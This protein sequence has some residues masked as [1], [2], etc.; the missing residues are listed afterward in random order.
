MHRS[1]ILPTSRRSRSWGNP[2]IGWA[3]AGQQPS[4]PTDSTGSP[5]N[6]HDSALFSAA[7]PDNNSFEKISVSVRADQ[8]A[9]CSRRRGIPRPQRSCSLRYPHVVKYHQC[10]YHEV[11]RTISNPRV[12]LQTSP[13]P[14]RTL[15]TRTAAWTT[16][17]SE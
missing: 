12:W 9:D 2:A 7:W 11:H 13:R 1:V 14:A 3:N 5:E 8:N 4:A 10:C 6:K 16:Q 17:V 15:T